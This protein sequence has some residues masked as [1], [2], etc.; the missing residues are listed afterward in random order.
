M[1]PFTH[2]IPVLLRKRY[3]FTRW[4]SPDLAAQAVAKE[5]NMQTDDKD[6]DIKH[7]NSYKDKIEEKL[8]KVKL[9]Y[10]LFRCE[11][12]YLTVF[13][14]GL[15]IALITIIVQKF[16]DIPPYTYIILISLFSIYFFLNLAITIK[17]W[18]GKS[19]AAKI[20]DEKMHFKERLVTGLEYAE[21]TEKNK[22]FDMLVDDITSKL[23]GKSIKN[24]LPHKFPKATKF[25]I[26]V[27]ILLLILLLFPYLYPEKLEQ[28]ITDIQESIVEKPG[29]L[30][31]T[32]EKPETKEAEDIVAEKKDEEKSKEPQEEQKDKKL[33]G[34]ETDKTQKEQQAQKTTSPLQN[35][36]SK[37]LSKINSTFDKL[38]NKSK[39]E[40][41]AEGGKSK[42]SDLKAGESQKKEDEPKQIAKTEKEQLEGK[43]KEPTKTADASDSDEK[44][45]EQEQAKDQKRKQRPKIPESKLLQ[46]LAKLLKSQKDMENFPQ[47]S[48]PLGGMDK[49]QA[50]SLK[51][52]SSQSKQSA[53]SASK[54]SSSSPQQELPQEELSKGTS[55]PDK[56]ET[57][58]S[59][60]GDKN[61][62]E[63]Q[64]QETNAG[65][66]DKVTKKQGDVKKSDKASSQ[67]P[68]GADTPA[69]GQ[70][71]SSDD[72][73]DK[74]AQADK[75]TGGTGSQTTPSPS[76]REDTE[77][78]QE[79]QMKDTPDTE[80]LDS[81]STGG[82]EQAKQEG[83]GEQGESQGA[84]GTNV[85]SGKGKESGSG[86]EQKG[87]GKEAGE[88]QKVAGKEPGEGQKGT[89]KGSGTEQKGAGTEPG[90]GQKVAGKE[91]GAEQ[92]GAGKEAGEGQKV[93]GKESG[94]GQKGA[95]EKSG[96]EQ[97]GAGKEAG[98]GQKVAGKEAGEGQKGAGTEP[99][100]G[101]KVA[102]RGSGSPIGSPQR[103]TMNNQ[104]MT[105]GSKSNAQSSAD[106]KN[107]IA[108]QMEDLFR[109]ISNLEKK[110]GLD[111]SDNM[112]MEKG[113]NDISKLKQE[114][115][116]KEKQRESNELRRDI[117]EIAAIPGSEPGKKLYS[118]EPEK[119]ETP[120][121]AEKFKLKL[122][123]IKDESGAKRETVSTGKGEATTKR[124]L[125][126]VGYDD[127]VELSKQQA[128]EDAIK[129][130]SIPL[131]YEEI[132]KKIHSEK[133]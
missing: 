110:M 16:V 28:I 81:K 123:G 76:A 99:G 98:E 41:K 131:E 35:E 45:P 116:D 23:D 113:L 32:L 3:N 66:E 133:E 61:M 63:T 86:A 19:E 82:T 119:I 53:S 128:E 37:L 59:G 10:N 107:K 64:Q 75:K 112:K 48:I 47:P 120:E 129:K 51:D 83:G 124:R 49:D 60:S 57:K 58:P 88:G 40:D 20:L 7:Q 103:Q 5:K 21:Q 11:N 42:L 85:A 90:E 25:F 4:N 13:T 100:E 72:L 38:E 114:G 29:L 31:N 2:F 84:G 9:R 77:L 26:P 70:K 92:K 1:A 105:G 54:D 71:G 111:V 122:E 74:L 17:K 39:T 46:K 62:P 34:T 94:E 117:S 36:I 93:A 12:T 78:P 33:A 97:K 121:S 95:G 130:T 91:S 106:L 87:A 109:Q 96:T 118:S 73:K 126:T 55:Q 27:S 30:N 67:V 43:E 18:I 127:T 24:T 14:I 44:P 132:I 56:S 65:T 108:S 69:K 22:F 15:A 8:E 6:D 102:S 89:G 79:Q 52:K 80:K 50:D 125:P 101:Q 115:I 68:E 104:G